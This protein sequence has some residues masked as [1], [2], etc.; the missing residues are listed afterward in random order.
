MVN[1][2]FREG[3]AGWAALT[4]DEGRFVVF[5]RKRALCPLP[6]LS[7]ALLAPLQRPPDQCCLSCTSSL[8]R[9]SF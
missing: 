5:I 7:A 6:A 9:D 3:F 1:E 8:L 2:K 4:A